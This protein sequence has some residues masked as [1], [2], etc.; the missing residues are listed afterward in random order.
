MKKRLKAPALIY[1]ALCAF[2]GGILIIDALNKDAGSIWFE[3]LLAAPMLAAGAVTLVW[4]ILYL[5]DR[6]IKT[7]A[8]VGFFSILSTAAAALVL[9]FLCAGLIHASHGGVEMAGAEEEHASGYQE[10]ISCVIE[11]PQT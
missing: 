2:V 5:R 4:L 11:E 10:E 6:A 8:V 3:C 7:R 1:I 9:M